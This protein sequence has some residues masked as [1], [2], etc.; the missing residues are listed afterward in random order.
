MTAFDQFDPFEQRITAAI[1]EIAAPRRP[2]YLDDLLG[3][4]ARTS[5]RPRWTFPGRWLPWDVRVIQSGPGARLPVRPLLV[6][7]I[8]ALLL[9]L[10]SIAVVGSR[11]QVPAPFGLADNGQVAYTF[12][13][14]V[15]VRDSLADPGRVLVAT[16]GKDGWP[17]YSP[18]GTRMLLT[19]EEA[20]GKTYSYVSDADGTGLRKI[21]PDPILGDGHWAWAPDSRTIA[22]VNNVRGFPVIHI[23]SVDDPVVRRL[24][25]DGLAVQ[26]ISWRPGLPDT[27]LFLATKHDGQNDLYT[28]RADGTDLRP[29][30]LPVQQSRF[31]AGYTNSGAVWSPD[32]RTIAYNALLPAEDTGITHFRVHLVDAD[33]RNDR[34]VVPRGVAEMEEGWPRFSPDGRWIL[35]HRWRFNGLYAGEGWLA[36]LPADGSAQARDIGPRIPGGEDTGL[37][38]AWS[39]DGTRVLMAT[40][41]TRET[42]S[43]DPVTG[44]YERLPWT[45][46]LPDWQRVNRWP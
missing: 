12:N 36:V 9:A 38:M 39:P 4:T 3:Q 24:D 41:N 17:L 32:G 11:N 26:D 10:A 43:I 21:L 40:Q 29:L 14:D 25:L 6:L 22:I 7:A 19:I 20:G 31:G 23:A 13:G 1:D 46:E 37:V 30:N 42:F 33:G 8:V 5:Q 2:D 18:D 35:V 34:A 27:L 44:D 16:A 45:E 28:V 15:W